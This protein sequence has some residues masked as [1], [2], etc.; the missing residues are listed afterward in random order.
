MH[1][2]FVI[3][4]PA[5]M[6]SQFVSPYDKRLLSSLEFNFPE[7]THAIGRL[8]EDSEGLLV[9]TTDKELTRKFLNPHSVFVKRYLVQVVY[10]VPEETLYRLRNGIELVIKQRGSYITKPCEVYRL[11][12]AP[13]LPERQSPY[14]EYIPHTWLEFVLTEGKNRQIRRMCKAVK[15]EC[16]RLVRTHIN[17]LSIGDMQAGEVREMKKEELFELLFAENIN[18]DN[19]ISWRE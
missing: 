6:I 9:L 5:G 2:Y 18:D 1:Q 7:G 12:N 19:S 10:E 11:Q 3:Y 15:H 17:Q 8:D 16:K 14:T 13:S 4:K